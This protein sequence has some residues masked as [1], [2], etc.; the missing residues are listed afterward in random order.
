MLLGTIWEHKEIFVCNLELACMGNRGDLS[1]A[2]KKKREK[3]E[4]WTHPVHYCSFALNKK[5]GPVYV[6]QDHA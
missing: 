6:S 4:K 2:G 1:P 3:E 5:V